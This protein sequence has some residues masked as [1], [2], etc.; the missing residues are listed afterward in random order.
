M[1]VYEHLT[2][3]CASQQTHCFLPTDTWCVS[4]QPCTGHQLWATPGSHT[5]RQP[6]THSTVALT[7]S[8]FVVKC[9]CCVLCGVS[10]DVCFAVSDQ[11]KQEREARG[12]E[13][14]DYALTA[15]ANAPGKGCLRESR[16]QKTAN[17]CH[18]CEQTLRAFPG[19]ATRIRSPLGNSLRTTITG[20]KQ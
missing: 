15:I 13:S 11:N 16:E 1:G 5:A 17:C 3:S 2:V 6:F 9:R 4:L 7:G 19:S 10:V 18:S 12:R 8:C 20:D 14:P